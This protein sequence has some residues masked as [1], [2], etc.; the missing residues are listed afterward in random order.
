MESVSQTGTFKLGLDI[1]F[2]SIMAEQN[3]EHVMVLFRAR[4][5]HDLLL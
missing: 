3:Q 1:Y 4:R 2:N 5:F